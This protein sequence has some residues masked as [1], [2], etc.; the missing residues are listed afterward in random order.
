MLRPSVVKISGERLD[1][2]NLH[3]TVQDNGIG[4][5]PKYL[6]RIFNIFQRLHGRKAFEG[7]GIGLSICRKI[8]ERH[9]GD[10]SANSAPGQGAC[11]SV[12]LP[13][14]HLEGDIP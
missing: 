2:E 3:L 13:F 4:F 11:F 1:G 9:G 6:D 10:I 14:K 7:S 12:T 5:D 8:A